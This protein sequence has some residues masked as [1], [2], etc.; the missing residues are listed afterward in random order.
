[1]N[2]V[3]D[4]II[5]FFVKRGVTVGFGISGGAILHC[6]DSAHYNENFRMIY[7]AHEQGACAMADGWARIEKK[8]GLCMVTSGPGITNCLTSVC[9]AWYDSIP[10]FI[11]SGQVA[12]NRLMTAKDKRDGRRQRGFQETPVTKI[13]KPV[14][15]AAVLVK[16]KNKV[17][18][19]VY[20]LFEI[21]M[22]GRPGPVLLDLCDDVQ[23]EMI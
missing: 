17:M 19:T 11:I 16:D 5:D 10:L 18:E 12:S 23:R 14:T 22:T 3:S 2:K 21:S 9:N 13:F 6:M 7:A 8:P 15:K 20:D 1:M 4:L